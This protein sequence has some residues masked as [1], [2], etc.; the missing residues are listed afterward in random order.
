MSVTRVNTFSIDFRAL[1]KRPTPPVIHDWIFENL[2]LRS[3]SIKMIQIDHFSKKV[4]VEMDTLQEALQ[5]VERNKRRSFLGEDGE[6]YPVELAMADGAV[7]VKVHNLPSGV[8][9]SAICNELNKYGTVRSITDDN[10]SS[11]VKYTVSRGVR[12]VNMIIKS[13]IPSCLTIENIKT[14]VTYPN[15]KRTCFNCNKEDHIVQQCPLKIRRQKGLNSPEV[16]RSSANSANSA[17]STTISRSILTTRNDSEEHQSATTDEDLVEITSDTNSLESNSQQ[18]NPTNLIQQTP[19]NNIETN[20]YNEIQTEN[21]DEV[22]DTEKELETQKE[23][24][25]NQEITE[26]G[27]SSSASSRSKDGPA[28]KKSKKSHTEDE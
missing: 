10:W 25:T 12:I 24:S 2:N 22:L 13:P 14:L 8:G 3:E 9:N 1:P 23:N 11:N 15:Q 7:N 16:R 4:F 28:K 21:H 5:T 19:G 17:T 27:P 6:L 18:E 26:S 20:Q